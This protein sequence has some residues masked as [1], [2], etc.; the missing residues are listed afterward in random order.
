MKKYLLA[1]DLGTSG[2]KATLYTTEGQL[3][4]KAV[5]NYNTNFFNSTWA[6]QDPDMWWRAVAETT[7]AIVEAIDPKTIAAVSFSGQMQGCVCVDH[8]GLPL[9]PAIIWAD[10]RAEKETEELI[11]QI[12]MERFYKITGHRPSPAYSIE[13]LMWVKNN[14]PDIYQR[15]YKMLLCK[16]YIIF[17]LTGCF[18][19]DYSDASGTNALDLRTMTWSEEIIKAAGLEI[20]KFPKL[21]ASTR[22]IGEVTMEAAKETGLCA[23][24]PIVMGGGDGA[25]AAIGAACIHEGDTYSCMGSSAWIAMTTSKP[26]YDEK[27]RTF[28]FAHIIPGLIMPCGTMQ[29]AGASYSWLK[30]ELALHENIEAKDK[31]VSAYDLINEKVRQSPAGANGIIYLPY[32]LGERSPRWNVNARGAFIGLKMESKREDMFRS[33][34]EGVI[35]NLNTILE[36]FREHVVIKEMLVIGGGAQSELWRQMMADIYGIPILKPNYLE[37]ATSMGA[38]ITAGVGAGLFENFEAIHRFLKVENQLEPITENREKYK[39]IYPVFESCYHALVNA[40]DEL[41]KL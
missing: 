7:K 4:K 30:R 9:R 27:M 21:A 34:A 13:K 8:K 18:A 31:G 25:C 23:R 14:E 1:H 10:Q 41:A 39:T 40:Y 5:Y 11:K 6:E 16:D 3:V 26:I 38:A 24:T 35:F 2:N 32:L 37:E 17:K 33:V 15:T 20:D 22:I 29:A 28:N 36:A 12:G 19:T